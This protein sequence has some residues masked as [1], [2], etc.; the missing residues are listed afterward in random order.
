MKNFL[1]VLVLLVPLLGCQGAN[2]VTGPDRPEP[3]PPE[4][5][6]AAPN[7]RLDPVVVPRARVV[8]L[9]TERPHRR[10]SPCPVA[11]ADFEWKNGPCEPCEHVP[12]GNFE[13]KNKPCYED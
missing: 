10:L 11:S 2:E 6:V 4:R 3:I 8:A 1:G 12:M 9:V 5:T 13:P 7:P